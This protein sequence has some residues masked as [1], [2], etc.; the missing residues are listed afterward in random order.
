MTSQPPPKSPELLTADKSRLV[1]IDVQQKF[2]PV[3]PKISQVI[4]NCVKLLKGAQ[5]LG[6]PCDAAEQ[7]PQ[8]LGATVEQLAGYLPNRPAKLRFSAAPSFPWWSDPQDATRERYQ[9]VVA[10]I[11]T[12]VCVLQT[13]F[14]LMARGFE[15]F[16]VVDSVN[17][18][19]PLDHE[20]ALKRMA[21][22]GAR[23]VTTEM[24]LF[25]WCEA[26][27][28][29]VFKQL[30]RIITGRDQPVTQ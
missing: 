30:S 13:V 15:V 21:D 27:G 17:G 10:G 3:V 25:E 11:E 16:V 7:Y 4:G 29:D 28:T 14:D 26:A 6:V 9:V 19:L 1:I 20:I 23:L 8:G 2:V 18:R 22:A 12:H 5:L 24:V